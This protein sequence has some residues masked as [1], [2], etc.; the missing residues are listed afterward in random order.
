[1][2]R[3]DFVK[4]KL[5]CV[6]SFVLHYDETYYVT[7]VMRIFKGA[8]FSADQRTGFKQILKFKATQD[9]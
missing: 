2:I 4:S 7:L 9:L 6:T 5:Y 8:W 1:M 3:Q